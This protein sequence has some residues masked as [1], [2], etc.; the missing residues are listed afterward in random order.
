MIR[1]FRVVI[2]ITIIPIAY[3]FTHGIFHKI[4]ALFTIANEI[5]LLRNLNKIEN[6]NEEAK[7]KFVN[8]K[9]DIEFHINNSITL[10]NNQGDDLW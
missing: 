3:I 5:L 8:I 2:F 1:L 9:K 6:L 7:L 10:D 4:F